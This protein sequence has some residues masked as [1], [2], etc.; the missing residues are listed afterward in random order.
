[1]DLLDDSLAPIAVCND[2]L[3]AFCTD[4]LFQTD[5]KRIVIIAPFDSV[6]DITAETHREITLIFSG[7]DLMDELGAMI[8]HW[9]GE[10][11]TLA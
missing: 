3:F 6:F 11:V 1:M 8:R 9:L 4:G 7:Q 10:S 2:M 5:K